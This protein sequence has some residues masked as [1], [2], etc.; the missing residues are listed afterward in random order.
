MIYGLV[1]I[2]HLLVCF[3]L[4]AIILVQGGRGGMA[5]AFGG[6]G[7]QSLFGGGANTVMTK[8]TA[9]GGG[10]FMVTCLA[11]AIASTARGRSVIEQVPT[12]LPGLGLPAP[13]S[14][15]PFPISTPQENKEDDD[16]NDTSALPD[17]TTPTK[18]SQ[19]PTS[20]SPDSIPEDS[21]EPVGLIENQPSSITDTPVSSPP[22]SEE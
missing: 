18:E 20:L 13:E 19:A 6:S 3:L 14:A 4:I 15:T 9:A 1:L 7:S 11:L 8:V 12:A 17:E 10:I 5:D 16:T 22:S 2:I 21:I